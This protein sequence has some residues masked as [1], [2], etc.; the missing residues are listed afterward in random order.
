MLIRIR[1]NYPHHL[2]CI[3]MLLY[4]VSRDKNRKN[5]GILRKLQQKLN[6]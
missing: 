5:S 6:V 4:N 2:K 3:Y 1:K